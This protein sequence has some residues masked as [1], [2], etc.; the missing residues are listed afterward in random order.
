MNLYSLA[1]KFPTEESAL[2]HLIIVGN[3][4]W[5]S[6]WHLTR[7]MQEFC[8]RYN[9]RGMQPWIFGMTLNNMICRKPLPYKEL[10]KF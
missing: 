6:P 3:Y 2:A 1:R 7:Y 4:P 10:V 5:L 9:R 8:W